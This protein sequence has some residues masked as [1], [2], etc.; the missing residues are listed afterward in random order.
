MTGKMNQKVMIRI[1]IK[2]L[3]VFDNGPRAH[4]IYFFFVIY[5]FEQ[6]V[7]T[8]LEFLAFVLKAGLFYQIP[9]CEN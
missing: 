8:K 7:N 2:S 4:Y 1:L 3:G 9:K 5:I 6:G